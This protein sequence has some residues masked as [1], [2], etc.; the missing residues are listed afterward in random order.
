MSHP[1]SLYRI[2]CLVVLLAMAAPTH[3]QNCDVCSHPRIIVYD[4]N[5][6][7]PQ[8]VRVDSLLSW[9][10]LAWPMAVTKVTIEENDPTEECL[11]WYDAAVVNSRTF[12]GDTMYVGVGTLALPPAGP[13][14]SAD[15]L[16]TATVSGAGPTKTMIVN[17]ETSVSREIV[18]TVSVNFGYDI[19]SQQTAGQTAAAAFMPLLTTIRDFEV[20]KRNSDVTVAIRDLWN[21]AT[22]AEIKVTPRK[23]QINV[24]E[25]VD[26]DLEMMDC[27]DV[28][29]GNRT[30][31]FIDTTVSEMA[32]PGS[33]GGTVSPTSVVTDVSGKA[34]VKF[35]AG[36]LPALGQIV[37]NYPH[38]K[39][40]GRPSAFFG[41]ASLVIS[42]PPPD[43]WMVQATLDVEE[44]R[45]IDTSWQSNGTS[46][47]F[48]VNDH[49]VSN[50][51]MS[52]LVANGAVDSVG[53]YFVAY[54]E[55]GDTIN[56]LTIAGSANE[57]Y[58]ESDYTSV[59]GLVPDAEIR[60]EQYRGCVQSGLTGFE[61]HYPLNPFDVA[62]V[63]QW[64]INNAQGVSDWKHTN[65]FPQPHWEED[66]GPVSTDLGF[67]SMFN[68]DEC[69]I[70]K[71]GLSYS[72]SADRTRIVPESQGSD[73]TQFTKTTEHLRA[74]ISKYSGTT[75]I[76]RS[77]SDLPLTYSLAQNYP[78]PFNPTT[79]IHYE[80]PKASQVRLSVYDVL[81]REVVTLVN[82]LKQPGRY[83]AILNA[84]TLASGVYF[85]R[86]QA[87]AFVQAK[88]LL[89]L[90]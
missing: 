57:D 24:N 50:G 81:G 52:M 86:L 67:S 44:D 14:N 34:T 65:L 38:K 72:V 4:A 63:V 77:K 53:F 60:V 55:E 80:L 73:G 51:S 19:T 35:T 29:L 64:G 49:T 2:G 25:S 76:P 28:P 58:F 39:P 31:S 23:T 20:N 15:Y 10:A 61:F 37:A 87:G 47:A 85:Y 7:V 3:A 59:P 22:P 78:N 13:V 11:T 56:R 36:P 33:T 69:T 9:F 70:V 46:G 43:L 21:A 6:L 83:E 40:C 75:G 79:T 41:N 1:K 27:D 45:T 66:A 26:V 74:T 5:L 17:L 32:I 71:S 62:I 12:H 8:P 54:E 84:T 18:K 30:I 89:L 90:R 42:Q 68:A 88:K 16:L 82:E 48:H